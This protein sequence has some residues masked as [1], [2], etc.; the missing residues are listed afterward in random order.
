MVSLSNHHGELVE[1]RHARGHGHDHDSASVLHEHLMSVGIDIGSSTS[2]LMFSRLTVG[3]PSP[4][5]RHP[6]VLD[7]EIVSRSRIML[8]PF[9]P[10][11]DLDAEPLKDL[12]ASAFADAGLSPDSIDTGAVIITGE[13]ARR[14]NAQRITELFSSSTGRFVCATA[15]PR[16]EAILAAHGCGAV[17]HSR[18]H[19]L[20]LL[21]V[22]IGG[23]TTKIST[24]D[25]G[26]VTGTGALNIGAR[27]VAFDESGRIVR[28]ER[29]G[30]EFLQSL[31]HDLHVSDQIDAGLR[32]KL[33]AKMADVLFA[34]LDGGPPPWDDLVV[35]AVPP[36]PETIDGVVF[37]GGVSEYVYGRQ[38]KSFGD[39]GPE[40][41][42]AVR[43]RAVQRSYDIMDVSEGIRATVIG[44][45][46]YSVQL[47]GE[48]ICIPDPAVLPLH[49][50]RIFV[51]RVTWD[52]PV[53]ERAERAVREALNSRDPEVAG[54]PYAV[55]ISSPSFIGYG[56]AMELGEGIGAALREMPAEDHP[57]LLIFEQNIGQIIGRNLVREMSIP[58]IDEVSLSEL[59]FIDVGTNVAGQA[60]VPVVVKSLAFGA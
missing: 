23:G 34:S 44:A 20:S 55:A 29:A 14:D 18:E 24:I 10:N 51:V 35:T 56:T 22:D 46:E 38:R 6:E 40:L 1:P 30:R 26:H 13:A 60:Y 37:S 48:T 2:H 16:L 12:I 47:S 31:G 50:L 33:A 15:G 36:L 25:R 49:N 7:R 4:Q 42:E 19:A 41:G 27:L 28:L 17:G 8:T 57:K 43:T 58:C 45:S 9:S 32:Q 59:D 5:Q 54:T 3:F 21:H 11:W 52:A 39:L 53:A